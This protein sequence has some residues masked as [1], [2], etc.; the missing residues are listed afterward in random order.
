MLV[1]FPRYDVAPQ[2]QHVAVPINP[3]TFRGLCTALAKECAEPN[4]HSDADEQR[5]GVCR[6]HAN[7][8]RPLL[9]IM[10]LS[11]KLLAFKWEIL[12]RAEL[13]TLEATHAPAPSFSGN[14]IQGF[15]LAFQDHALH[16][17]R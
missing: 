13:F 17:A 11:R 14:E 15:L 9:L 8:A 16:Y 10:S 3:S 12:D 6:V 4:D 1:R 7:R 5:G 2:P